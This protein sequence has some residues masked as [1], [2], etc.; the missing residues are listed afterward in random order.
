LTEGQ[1]CFL[2]NQKNRFQAEDEFAEKVIIGM[3]FWQRNGDKRRITALS[4]KNSRFTGSLTFKLC[5]FL[6][7]PFLH[8]ERGLEL[9]AKY[10]E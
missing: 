4:D 10:L 6:I 5:N 3:C 1:A 7:F 8:G 2:N 9:L